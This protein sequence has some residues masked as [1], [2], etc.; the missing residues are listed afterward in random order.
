[1]IIKEKK[2]NIFAIE[3]DTRANKIKGLSKSQHLGKGSP[4]NEII[5]GNKDGRI[6]VKNGQY[7]LKR[8][9]AESPVSKVKVKEKIVENRETNVER[10]IEK[11]S[12]ERV[13]RFMYQEIS[14][15]REPAKNRDKFIE[16]NFVDGT[17]R[18]IEEGTDREYLEKL[19]LDLGDDIDSGLDYTKTSDIPF[20]NF[21]FENASNKV[22]LEDEG[23]EVYNVLTNTKTT[24]RN[25]QN[26]VRKLG[27][28]GERIRK[29]Q[30]HVLNNK[31]VETSIM[32][33]H[34]PKVKMKRASRRKLYKIRKKE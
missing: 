8:N 12:N 5:V 28:L 27:E 2:D 31:D 21:T 1:M 9:K 23:L 22:M 18:L 20:V 4:N 10:T 25:R 30:K 14:T 11:K 24:K 34:K 16:E 13:M 6:T 17:S 32:R 3:K 19:A 26:C 33:F 7:E 15:S 29:L